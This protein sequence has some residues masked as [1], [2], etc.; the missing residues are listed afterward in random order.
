VLLNFPWPITDQ[1]L[2]L[3]NALERTLA[4][5]EPRGVNE[6]EWVRDAAANLIVEAYNQGVR[7]EEALAHYAL[8]ALKLGRRE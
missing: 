4:A 8:K 3:N 7:D 2:L 1:E 5:Y 6:A